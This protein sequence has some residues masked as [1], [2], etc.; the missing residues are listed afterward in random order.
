[1]GEEQGSDVQTTP[2]PSP[3]KAFGKA[4]VTSYCWDS[5][6]E[7][8]GNP[9]DAILNECALMVHYKASGVYIGKRRIQVN[10]GRIGTFMELDY[11]AK[12]APVYEAAYQAAYQPAYDA[13]IDDGKTPT[14]ALQIAQAAARTAATTASPRATPK[15]SSKS[16][17][18][19]SPLVNQPRS[20]WQC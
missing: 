3:T 11:K 8:E 6:A 9:P 5:D 17:L 7:Q 12:R 1:M 18:T 14:E 10:P 2:K 13:A 20:S 15:Q 16:L 19:R 4:I